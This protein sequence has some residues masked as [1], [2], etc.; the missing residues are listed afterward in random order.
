VIA[1][2]RSEPNAPF[3]ALRKWLGPSSDF[4]KR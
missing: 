1:L 4:S 2:A 3:V